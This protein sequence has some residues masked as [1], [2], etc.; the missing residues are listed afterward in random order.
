MP[1]DTRTPCWR[2]HGYVAAG[3][4]AR[5][6][7]HMTLPLAIHSAAAKGRKCLS[8]QPPARMVLSLLSTTSCSLTIRVVSPHSWPETSAACAHGI[9]AAH[10]RP[11]VRQ[12][13]QHH[14]AEDLVLRGRP[15]TVLEPEARGVHDLSGQE[16]GKAIVCA[17]RLRH[18][19]GIAPPAKITIASEHSYALP[20]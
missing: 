7:A 9:V 12:R 11:S 17:R 14:S 15:H 18:V 4:P 6:Q 1:A 10:D 8:A 2:R 16:G 13:H 5:L 3:R 20:D 19:Q